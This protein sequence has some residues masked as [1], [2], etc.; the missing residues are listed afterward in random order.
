MSATPAQSPLEVG[1]LKQLLGFE[2]FFSWLHNERFSIGKHPTLGHFIWRGNQEDLQKITRL[3]YPHKALRRRAADLAGWP[4][5]QI[6]EFPIQLTPSEFKTYHE[7]FNEYIKRRFRD[8][9][10]ALQE[11][12]IP[13][14]EVGQL[15]KQVSLLKAPYTLQFVK[16]LLAEGNQVAVYAEYLDTIAALAGELKD[17][18]VVVTGETP[19]EERPGLIEQF[20]QG[21]KPVILFTIYQSINLQQRTA[22]DTPRVQINH[23]VSWSGLRAIQVNGRCH[24]NG[25]HAVI[26]NAFA[27]S[28]IDEVAVKRMTERCRAASQLAG[29][30]PDD[31]A[32]F[33]QDVLKSLAV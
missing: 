18:C 2:N 7:A 29:D 1:Y 25:M 26:Y 13:L 6:V 27:E 17:V 4:E 9:K 23:D 19:A 12:Y 5:L 28:T 20:Q 22:E 32:Q 15:R 30:M 10:Q 8:G 3:L 31:E 33:S 16:D 21:I 24:R 11:D 14:V